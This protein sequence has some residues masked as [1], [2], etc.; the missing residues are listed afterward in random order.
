MSDSDVEESLAQAVKLFSYLQDKDVFSEHYRNALAKRLLNGTT[1]VS[2]TLTPSAA[3]EC[4]MCARRALRGA[5]REGV[6]RPSHCA[7]DRIEHRFDSSADS[8]RESMMV[9]PTRALK[10]I[11]LL[12]S[13]GCRAIGSY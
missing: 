3:R 6:P 9:R 5:P 7:C 10:P 8:A 1:K 11:R 4:V 12:R 13:D 2:H